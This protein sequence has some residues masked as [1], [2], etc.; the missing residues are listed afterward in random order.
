MRE[1][2]IAMMGG[3]MV[4]LQAH[5]HWLCLHTQALLLSLLESVY[6]MTDEKEI[7]ASEKAKSN[8]AAARM[9]ELASFGRDGTF[10]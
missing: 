6:T 1:V 2:A 9:R 7:L 8:N 10:S 3:E 5:S 4:M